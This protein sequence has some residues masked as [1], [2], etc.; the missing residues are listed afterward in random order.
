MIKKENNIHSFIIVLA[1]FSRQLSA[2]QSF[3]H[4]PPQRD[5]GENPKK[6]KV[7]PVS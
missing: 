5:R 6:K 4:S 7:K 1:S 2:T 3:F